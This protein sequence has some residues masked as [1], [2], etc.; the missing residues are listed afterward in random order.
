MTERTFQVRTTIADRCGCNGP[1]AIGQAVIELFDHHSQTPGFDHQKEVLFK[2]SEEGEPQEHS[3][4]EKAY[5]IQGFAE[6]LTGCRE[7][8]ILV[9]EALQPWLEE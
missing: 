4:M 9:R 3:R 2:I 1:E 5:M 6:R 7:T 8:S